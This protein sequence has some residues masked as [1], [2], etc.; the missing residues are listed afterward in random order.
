MPLSPHDRLDIYRT[1]L[2]IRATELKMV[3]LFKKG[4]IEGHMLPCLGQEAIPATLCKVYAPED[5]LVTAHRGGGHYIAK[6]CDYN[7][8]WAEL[9]GRTTG[10]TKGRGGQI[11]LMDMTHN[12]I[13]GNAVVGQHWG[14]ATGGGYVARKKGL[15]LVAV[16][17]EGSTNR[18]TFHE[19]L[20]MSAVQKLPILYVIEFNN[21]QMFSS[22]SETTA[23]ER[24]SERAAPYH[25]PGVTV[26]GDDPDAIYEKAAEYY[27]NVKS[28]NGPCLIEC[29]THKWTDSVSNLREDPKVVENMKKPENDCICRFETKLFA[30]GILGESGKIEINDSVREQLE[31]ALAYAAGSPQ[32]GK[33]DGINEVYSQPVG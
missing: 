12:A 20:N 22:S 31:A 13:T 7:A 6:G 16:G 1:M 8:L 14:I 3:E 25:I 27:N 28:G 24:I 23:C 18:G 9:Y 30:E 2:L 32:P 21:N 4:I 26:D 5:F 19:S 29:V 15:V 17:G 11:H 10:A 33:Y